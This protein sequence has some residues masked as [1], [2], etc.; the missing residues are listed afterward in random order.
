MDTQVRTPQQVFIH[1]QRL[2]VP[3][4]QRPYVWNEENQWRPL[5]RDIERV[6][7]R[8]LLTGPGGK[9]SPTSWVLSCCSS[10]PT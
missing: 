7:E 8:Q 1:T 4:F 10:F 2:I 9:V 5:W 6:A 3:L